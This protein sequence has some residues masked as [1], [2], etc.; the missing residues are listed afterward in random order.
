MSTDKNKQNNPE[1][2]KLSNLQTFNS[3]VKKYGFSI[4]NFYDVHFVPPLL[5]PKSNT[6]Q[7]I[8][9][10]LTRSPSDSSGNSRGGIK[11]KEIL[12]YYADECSLPGHQ[13]ATGEYRINNSPMMK[14]AYGV[15]NSE[16]NISFIC[17]GR[18][19]VKK[20]FD[21]WKEYIHASAIPKVPVQ[22][23]NS[24]NVNVSRDLNRSRYRDD[25]TC[26]LVII[27]F[28]RG[29]S[30]DANKARLFY[31]DRTIIPDYIEENLSVV[32]T[33]GFG[34]ALPTYSVRLV[35][36]FPINVS[37]VALSSGASEL[38]R[39]QVSFEYDA[40]YTNALSGTGTVEESITTNANI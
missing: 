21:A 15:V 38:T 31:S 35:N 24:Y 12:R 18:S 4:S 28:E 11:A 17:D 1:F 34:Y 27:K 8:Q 2:D 20:T 30:S 39:V 6:N 5:D 26:D 22:G 3:Y 23:R 13:M 9:N 19:E 32:K 10:I 33:K 16:V 36:A 14:Y 37:S 7:F 25:Y 40:I 29:N